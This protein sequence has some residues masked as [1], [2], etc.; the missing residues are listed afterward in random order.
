MGRWN[1]DAGKERSWG[2]VLAQSQASQPITVRA[3][4]TARGI[5][6]PSFYAWRREIQR[7]DRD[8]PQFLPV[9]VVDEAPVPE[10]DGSAIEVVLGGGHCLRV[11]PGFDRATLVRLLEALGERGTPC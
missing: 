6:Q 4:C 5:S 7:R 1:R 3:F 8:R 10:R 11:R 9:R 2:Q